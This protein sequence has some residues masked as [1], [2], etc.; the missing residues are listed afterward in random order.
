MPTRKL[1]TAVK[2][3]TITR[4]DFSLPSEVSPRT[5]ARAN[6]RLQLMMPLTKLAS[7]NNPDAREA[8]ATAVNSKT[9]EPVS[10]P[11]PWINPTENAVTLLYP[12]VSVQVSGTF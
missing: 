8:L 4:T 12:A 9:C 3:L 1:K 10:A 6:I 2:I 7:I 5:E 11:I